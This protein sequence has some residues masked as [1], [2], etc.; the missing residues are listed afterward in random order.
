MPE[1]TAAWVQDTHKR[2]SSAP[3]NSREGTLS[4]ALQVNPQKQ[5]RILP[6]PLAPFES[7]ASDFCRDLVTGGAA[8]WLTSRK[9]V[10]VVRH[11]GCE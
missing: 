9:N 4:V 1:G 6:V 10:V 7:S 3:P 5:V 11:R 8:A 2:A